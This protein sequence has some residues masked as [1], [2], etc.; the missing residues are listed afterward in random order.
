MSVR[1]RNWLK[2]GSLVGLAFVLGLLFAG[3]LDFPAPAQAQSQVGLLAQ[4]PRTAVASP[5]PTATPPW[6]PAPAPTC[7]P[8]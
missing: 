5:V 6:P 7:W 4:T 1:T 2:F 8:P 3:V